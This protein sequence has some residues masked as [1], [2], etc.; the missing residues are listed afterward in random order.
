MKANKEKKH[1]FLLVMLVIFFIFFL[2]FVFYSIFIKNDYEVTKQV[3]CDPKTDSCF[4]SDCESNDPTCDTTTTYKKI[5]VISKYAGSDFES[6][7][8]LENSS[9]CKII[10]C[11]EDTVEAGEKCFK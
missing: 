10:T 1:H 6:L 4:V 9:I 11:Q 2:S 3:S 8:C 5:S 7:T